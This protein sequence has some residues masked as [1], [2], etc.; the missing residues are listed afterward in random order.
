MRLTLAAPA[1]WPLP[2][3]CAIL[4]GSRSNLNIWVQAPLIMWRAGTHARPWLFARMAR[5]SMT[6]TVETSSLGAEA[7]SGV[8][9]QADCLDCGR[10]IRAL[11]ISNVNI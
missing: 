3:H 11:R 7:A 4:L 2:I 8:P 9:L 6:S 10:S 5:P 1:D